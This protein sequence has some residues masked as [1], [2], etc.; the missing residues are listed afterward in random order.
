MS[1]NQ[2]SIRDYIESKWTTIYVNKFT[3][4]SAKQFYEEFKM[5]QDSGQTVLPIVILLNV[6]YTETSVYF[7]CGSIKVAPVYIAKSSIK[8]LRW[9]AKPGDLTNATFKAPLL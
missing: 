4:E 1:E 6:P 3:E 8:F 7:L 9:P 5:A 2:Q